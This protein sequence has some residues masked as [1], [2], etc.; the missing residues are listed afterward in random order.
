MSRHHDASG[1]VTK[2]YR[3]RKVIETQLP[4]ACV[5]GCGRL[6]TRDDRWHVAHIIPAAL[7]GDT[8]LE[9]TGPAHASCNTRAGAKLGAS[10]YRRARAAET[11]IRPW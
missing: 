9:N 8:T 4:L 7:G 3:V 2:A 6:V 1:H 5:E 10:I 11:G